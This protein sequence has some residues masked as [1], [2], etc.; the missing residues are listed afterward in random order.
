MPR[1][2]DHIAQITNR[3]QHRPS[4]WK[5]WLAALAGGLAV[6]ASFFLGLVMLILALG[7]AT[8]L[9]LF[10]GIR[11]W[12]LRRQLRGDDGPT[13]Q[14]SGQNYQQHRSKGSKPGRVIEGESVDI[15]DRD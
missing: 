7:V 11:I 6:V 1:I 5:R 12:W 2:P 15:S 10:I 13:E 9:A 3:L 4:R 8:A 14:A